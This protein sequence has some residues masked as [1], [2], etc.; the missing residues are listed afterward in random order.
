MQR[1]KYMTPIKKLIFPEGISLALPNQKK[2][3]SASI[4]EKL[5]NFIDT[6]DVG[7]LIKVIKPVSSSLIAITLMRDFNTQDLCAAVD[8]STE[9]FIKFY[10]SNFK[11]GL[12]S[13]TRIDLSL[14]S[15]TLE[16][17]IHT[18]CDIEEISSKWNEELEC[19]VG[20]T[21]FYMI[22]HP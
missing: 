18:I 13:R 11:L 15:V 20:N 7:L 2:F 5:Q 14:S 9:L 4:Y 16:T 12:K 1:T 10:D 6:I 3:M 21:N 8:G 22:L 17:R 19:Y